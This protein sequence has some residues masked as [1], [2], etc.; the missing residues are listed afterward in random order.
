MLL[1]A[2]NIHRSYQ[3]G[4]NELKVL[5]GIDL[6]VEAGEVVAIVGPSGAGKS[7]LLNI[8][9][10]LDQPNQG[11]ILYNNEDIYTLSE[12]KRAGLRNNE[13]GF[14]FQ[15]YY[16]IPELTALE[17]VTLPALIK[18]Q[19]GRFKSCSQRAEELLERVGLQ[20]RLL[21]RPNQMSG[22]E[23]QRVAMARAMMNEPKLIFCDEPTGNLD[24]KSG[25]EMIDLFFEFN[26]NNNQTF[27]IV[28]H[29][30]N[31]A[32][33]SHRTVHMKDGLLTNGSK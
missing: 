11:R 4:K 28:T 14:I 25:Q 33:C 6:K 9:G 19:T 29:D 18:H 27:V 16:L 31:I 26:K 3:Y 21:S 32:R 5:K 24:S 23:Q 7:T 1:E 13:L 30:E 17:N 20:D 12:K 22:G 2:I 8:C 15:F 10:A